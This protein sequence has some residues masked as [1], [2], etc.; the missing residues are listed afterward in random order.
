MVSC[1]LACSNVPILKNQFV[2]YLVLFVAYIALCIGGGY[3]FFYIEGIE[4][5]RECEAVDRKIT[6]LKA[7]MDAARQSQEEAAA[8]ITSRRLS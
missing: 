4:E 8:A 7:A 6:E 3:A 5:Q 1:F 2:S